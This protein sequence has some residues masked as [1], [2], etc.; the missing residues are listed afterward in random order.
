MEQRIGKY[1]IHPAAG[2]FPLL[3]GEEYEKFKA[4]IQQQGQQETIKVRGD[5]LIDGRNRLRAFIHRRALHL[6]TARQ[7]QERQIGAGGEQAADG[8]EGGR[9]N[10]K[11]LDLKSD[12]R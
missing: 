8:I 1:S 10:K 6:I 5:L 11:P 2:L 3:E 9:G 12:P 7:A 4:S